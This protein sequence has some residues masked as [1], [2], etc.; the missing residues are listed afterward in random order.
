MGYYGVLGKEVDGDIEA[1][2]CGEF[3]REFSMED[4]KAKSRRAE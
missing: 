4:R 1:E 3:E 2:P